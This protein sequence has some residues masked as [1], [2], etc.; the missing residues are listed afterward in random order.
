MDTSAEF[1]VSSA[2]VLLLCGWLGSLENEISSLEQM[3]LR[4]KFRG[5]F[6]QQLIFTA[7]CSLS[8]AG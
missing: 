8:G 2:I 3:I 7:T 4:N 5:S 6:G 1:V